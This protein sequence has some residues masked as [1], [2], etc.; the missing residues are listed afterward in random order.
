ML[1]HS[2]KTRSILLIFALFFLVNIASSG[3]HLD[4]WDG[5]E[6]FFVTESMV[7]KHTAKLD[8]S[9][10][11]V[12]ETN[13]NVTYTVH[14]NTWL[15]TGKGP[16]INNTTLEPVYTV[17]SL[18]LSASAVPFYYLSFL[19]SIPPIEVIGLLVNSLFISLICVVVY[20]FSWDIH[21]SKKIAFLL[22]LI[23]GVCSFLW[24]FNTTLWMQP[25]QA[26]TLI[27]SAYFIYK[28]LHYNKSLI[29][30][31]TV[32]KHDKG[33]FFAGLGGLCLGLSV[34][35]NPTSAVFVPAFAVYSIYY[36]RH[37]KKNLLLFLSM[38]GI[39]LLL[40]GF[41]NNIRFGG[42]TNFGYGY[43]ESLAT[44]DGWRGL[45]GLLISPGT[46][47][48]FYFP[49]AILLPLGA[50]YM[51]KENR[52]LF[53]L[54]GSVLILNWINIGTLSYNSEPVSWSG[55]PSWGPR[56]LIPLLPFIV[57]ILG[58]IFL[59]LRRKIFLKSII[60]SLCVFGFFVNLT[61]VLFWYHYGILYVWEIEQ[62]HVKH[63]ND[64]VDTMTWNQIYSP[65][66]IHT[67][68]LLSDYIS[69][70]D[71]EQYRT[72]QGYYYEWI[73]LG[74]A[75]CSYDIYLYC[76]LGIAPVLA[77]S[78]PIAVIAVFILREIRVPIICKLFRKKSS[79]YLSLN[80]TTK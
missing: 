51:Y 12:K 46:G 80:K 70:V 14:A 22:S 60:I 58:N 3:G 77:I 43:Y 42:F 63:P 17:R 79:S 75:P 27:S 7:L 45:V 15:Q 37:N 10:P 78:L 72:D 2:G 31:Y 62:L 30:H 57:L 26:L 52:A 13:F 9:V 18:L 49:I 6:A 54:F 36:M 20:C 29:C 66:I 59:H 8:P 34:F 74:L 41:L 4:Q 35:S 28:S 47:L 5:M 23:I 39:A 40:L 55:G 73:A 24:P 64:W 68:A 48:L 11:S 67:K 69:S 16:N 65:I 71:P 53:L 50:K 56:Y 21:G 19:L 76:N 61:G 38:L 33:G 44:H 25:L 32:L 1:P